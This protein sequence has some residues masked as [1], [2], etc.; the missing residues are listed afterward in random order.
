VSESLSRPTTL[1]S[2]DATAA[3]Y[4]PIVP[5]SVAQ[6]VSKPVKPRGESTAGKDDRESPSSIE[7]QVGIANKLLESRLLNVR[8]EIDPSITGNIR[9]VMTDPS[10]RVVREI[11]SRHID[12]IMEK[13]E[14]LVSGT[15][16][17]DR[18]SGILIDNKA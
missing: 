2:K 18:L 14:Q 17:K 7:K 3:P 12:A 11:P 6:A 5:G 15:G 10:N 4:S 8:F 16:S 13:V 9:I 1:R